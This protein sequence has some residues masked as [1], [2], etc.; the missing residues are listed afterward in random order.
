M[1]DEDVPFVGQPEVEASPGFSGRLQAA[2]DLKSL[3]GR[4]QRQR[5]HAIQWYILPAKRFMTN[6][7]PRPE[8]FRMVWHIAHI[9]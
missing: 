5:M 2:L 1:R 7:K 8:L 9:A 3:A 4:L 6:R